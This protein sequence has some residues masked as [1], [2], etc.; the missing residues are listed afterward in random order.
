ML[1]PAL[2][3]ATAMARTSAGLPAG[4]RLS[5]HISLG[6]IATTFPLDEKR[7]RATIDGASGRRGGEERNP[8]APPR[9]GRGAAAPPVR[10]GGAAGGDARHQGRLVPWMAAGQPGRV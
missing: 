10:A 2:G 3:R 8:R 9:P 5:D 7:R 1:S 4:I 6:V